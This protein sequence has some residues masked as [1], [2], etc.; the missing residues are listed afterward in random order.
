MAIALGLCMQGLS[1]LLQWLAYQKMKRQHL[2][3]NQRIQLGHLAARMQDF[4]HLSGEMGVVPKLDSRMVANDE[5][6]PE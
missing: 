5:I 4:L 3:D 1:L 2:S 6:L